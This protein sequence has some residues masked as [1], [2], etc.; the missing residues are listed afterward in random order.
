MGVFEEVTGFF[1][2]GPWVP[3]EAGV[4]L[5]KV[6]VFGVDVHGDGGIVGVNMEELTDRAGSSEI[7]ASSVMARR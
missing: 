5:E 7:L 1:E 3:L 6:L 2:E 4:V